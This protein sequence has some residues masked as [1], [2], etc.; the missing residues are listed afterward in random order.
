MIRFLIWAL[1]IYLLYKLI[2][3]Y[4]PKKKTTNTNFYSQTNKN[5][6]KEYKIKAEDIIE[7]DYEEIK[8]N[9]ENVQNKENI[10]DSE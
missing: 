6:K 8:I 1:L 9:K 5:E 4:F 3:S 2:K 10:K 7:A